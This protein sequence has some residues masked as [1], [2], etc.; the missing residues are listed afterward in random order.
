MHQRSIRH[1]TAQQGLILPHFDYQCIMT[2]H[3]PFIAD[4][5][6]ILLH[7]DTV[8]PDWPG[9]F[10][11]RGIFDYYHPILAEIKKSDNL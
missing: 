7:S 11:S 6:Y 2:A 5:S 1:P 10:D 3:A 4:E 9:T 8:L